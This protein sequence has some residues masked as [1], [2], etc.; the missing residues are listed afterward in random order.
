[1]EN[2]AETF[3][4]LNRS[5][6]T[7]LRGVEKKMRRCEWVSLQ[8]I[9]K[10]AKRS[11]QTVDRKLRRLS[12]QNLIF[13]TLRPY[14]GYQIGFRAYDVIALENLVNRDLV[15]GLGDRLGVGKES[16]VYNALGEEEEPLAIKFHREGETSF[17]H[18]RQVRDHLKDVPRCAWIHAARLAARKEFNVMGRLYPAVSVPKPVALS[19]HA[20]VMELVNGVELYKVNLVNPEDCLDMILEE[21]ASAWKIGFV[22]ADLS[23]YNVLIADE[24]IKIIDWPQAVS[25]RHFK[26]RWFLQRDLNNITKH[27][28]HRYGLEITLEDSLSRVIGEDTDRKVMLYPEKYSE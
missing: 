10:T 17:K 20:L 3:L 6:L 2:L 7:I 21:A 23:A 11:P 13:K 9:I 1:M 8:D 22:H 15:L 19:Y 5:D 16:V 4:S 24:D 26:A 28:Q 12:G 14:E 25:V 18:V 27:F